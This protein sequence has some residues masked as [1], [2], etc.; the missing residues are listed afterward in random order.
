[1]TCL[2]DPLKGYYSDFDSKVV[3]IIKVSDISVYIYQHI[4]FDAG[5]GDRLP[6]LP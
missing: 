6:E 1:M 5:A 3:P 4:D 2:C